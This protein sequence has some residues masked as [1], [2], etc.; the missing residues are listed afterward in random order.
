MQTSTH[1]TIEHYPV[2]LIDFWRAANGVRYLLRPCCRRTRVR[3]ETWSREFREIAAI[4]AFTVRSA[5]C[6]ERAFAT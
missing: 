5:S 2:D 4:G 1:D 3:S 6:R